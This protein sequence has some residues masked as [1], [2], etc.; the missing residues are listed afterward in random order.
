M[1]DLRAYHDDEVSLMS[2]IKP[3]CSLQLCIF[4]L[5]ISHTI[6]TGNYTNYAQYNSDKSA[7]FNPNEIKC[8]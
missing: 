2:K 8:R 3:M 6:T 5:S 7:A 1:G 4:L